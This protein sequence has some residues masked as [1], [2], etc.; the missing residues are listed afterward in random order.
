MS[1]AAS[2]GDSI[3]LPIHGGANAPSRAR[4]AVLSRLDHRCSERRTSDIALIVSELVTNSVV[5]A[6]VGADQTVTVELVFRAEQLLLTVVDPGSS[7]EPHRRARA[8]NGTAGHLGLF[9]VEVL[10]S[11]WG[12]DRDDDGVT[13]VWCEISLQ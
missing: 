1:V 8:P 7:L 12:F 5:H 9:L 10:S 11:A 2:L 6:R 3:S 13:R 4:E